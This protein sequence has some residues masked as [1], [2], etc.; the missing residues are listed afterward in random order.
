MCPRERFSLYKS[1]SRLVLCYKK[2]RATLL[3]FIYFYY[4]LLVTKYL[5]TKLS[6]TT[7]FSTCKEYLAENR[8][9]FPS[10]P[11]WVRHSYLSKGLRLISYTCGSTYTIKSKWF[12]HTPGTFWRVPELF[13]ELLEFFRRKKPKMFRSCRNRFACFSLMKIIDPELFR[14]ASRF[15]LVGTGNVLDLQKKFR[16]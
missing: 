3:H 9:S 10:A 15:I 8:L 4:L 2:D 12:R 13:W 14:N 7:Y 6:V 16:I 5:T 11:R 1:L